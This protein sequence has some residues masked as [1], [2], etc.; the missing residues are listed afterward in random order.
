MPLKQNN[1]GALP[2]ALIEADFDDIRERIRS[3]VVDF[4]REASQEWIVYLPIAGIEA[5]SGNS[6]KIGRACLKYMNSVEME[7]LRGKVDKI[8]LTPSAPSDKAKEANVSIIWKQAEKLNK[9]VCALYQITAESERAKEIAEEQTQDVLDL[10]SYFISFIHSRDYK[11][12]VR[13]QGEMASG[14]RTTL[15][16]TSNAD[17]LYQANQRTGA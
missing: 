15:L 5:I 8:L 13:L 17:R 9:T 1:F 7:V 3:L 12:A 2:K 6:L 11:G 10:L 4:D 14:H 16:L